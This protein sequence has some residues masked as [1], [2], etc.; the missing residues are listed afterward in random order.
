MVELEILE[1]SALGDMDAVQTIMA[2]CNRLGVTFSLDDFGTGYS[3][4]TYLRR[5]PVDIL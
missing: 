1:T 3:S 5:L 4:L 2:A